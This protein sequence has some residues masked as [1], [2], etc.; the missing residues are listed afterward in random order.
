MTVVQADQLC[1]RAGKRLLTAAE[2]YVVARGSPDNQTSCATTGGLQ[3]TGAAPQCVSGVGVFDTVGNVW[4]L[5]SDTVSDG[6][7]DHD[8]LPPSGYVTAILP[9]GLPKMT[10]A[11]PNVLYN[12]DYFWNELSTGT[13]AVM[14]GG[15]YGSG[16]DGGMYSAHADTEQNFSS[17]A[18]GFR[19]VRELQH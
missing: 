16:E 3:T 7:I 13:F 11:T 17:T 2:W 19:C 10:E 18:V 8:T 12:N 6:K 1:A 5:V 14:R 4:E 15:F 9:S